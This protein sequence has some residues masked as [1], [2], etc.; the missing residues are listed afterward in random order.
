MRYGLPLP[1]WAPDRPYEFERE[2]GY[3]ETEWL[4]TALRL[5]P[6]AERSG[7]RTVTVRDGE[8]RLE[9]EVL[10]AWRRD[11]A[12]MRIPACRVRF[13]LTGMDA[14]QVEAWLGQIERRFQRGGG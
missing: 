11:I 4:R 8:A 7:P 1:V 3:S 2:M 5:S 9:M 14:A 10:E 13:R 6:Q 12:R